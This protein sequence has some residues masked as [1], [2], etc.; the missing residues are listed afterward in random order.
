MLA[1]KIPNFTKYNFYRSTI[2]TVN[3]YYFSAI[4]SEI[5]HIVI[6]V[7]ATIDMSKNEMS[8]LSCK[9]GETILKKILWKNP[10]YF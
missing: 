1:E 10:I 5:K 9:S 8:K 6:I 7:Q 3:F 2:F 4:S